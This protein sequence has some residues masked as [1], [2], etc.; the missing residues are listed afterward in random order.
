MDKE[1][2]WDDLRDLVDGEAVI[3]DTPTQN[4]L[5]AVT[6]FDHQIFIYGLCVECGHGYIKLA[7]DYYD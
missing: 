7:F 3:V 5:D 1:M 2:T 4:A 6:C